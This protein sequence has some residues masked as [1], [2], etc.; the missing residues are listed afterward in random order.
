[1]VK[2]WRNFHRRRLYQITSAETEIFTKGGVN[3]EWQVVLATALAIPL[4]LLPAVLIWF[5]IIGG[6]YQAGQSH[7]KDVLPIGMSKK[8]PWLLE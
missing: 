2:F 3:M 8:G 1:V 7:E 5:L 6:I 4:I